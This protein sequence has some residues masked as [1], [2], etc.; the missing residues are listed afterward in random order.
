MIELP[1]TILLWSLVVLV[2]PVA[3]VGVLATIILILRKALK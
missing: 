3:M 2:T 1:L